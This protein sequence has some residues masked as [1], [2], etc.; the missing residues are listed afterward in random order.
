[1]L[2]F[3]WLS[4]WN[5]ISESSLSDTK[6]L[7]SYGFRYQIAVEEGIWTCRARMDGNIGVTSVG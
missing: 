6:M 4:S 1:M 7:W 3:G 5:W 2:H